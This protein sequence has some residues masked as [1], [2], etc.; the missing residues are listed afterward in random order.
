LLAVI[1]KGQGLTTV[2]QTTAGETIVLAH[3]AAPS[4]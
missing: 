2:D 1:G 3:D 4:S